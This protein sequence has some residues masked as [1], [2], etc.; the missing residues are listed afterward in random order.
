MGRSARRQY[1]E[2]T[3]SAMPVEYLTPAVED[4]ALEVQTLLA[5]R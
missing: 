1:R 5:D 3:P 4:R 2:P